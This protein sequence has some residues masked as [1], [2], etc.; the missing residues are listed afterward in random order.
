MFPKAAAAFT[1]AARIP[2][3]LSGTEQLRGNLKVRLPY[4]P[5]FDWMILLLHKLFW[6]ASSFFLKFAPESEQ[7]HRLFGASPVL[8]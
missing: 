3:Q 1:P 4:K 7:Y 5:L 2:R 8:P 6:D